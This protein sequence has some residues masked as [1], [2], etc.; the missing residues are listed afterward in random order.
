MTDLQC[1][2]CNTSVSSIIS[3]NVYSCGHLLCGNCGSD[4]VCREDGSQTAI[5]DADVLQGIS[6]IQ[7][8]CK[9]LQASESPDWNSYYMAVQ[10]LRDLVGRKYPS[11]CQKGH[12]YAGETCLRCAEVALTTQAQPLLQWV[13]NY[14]PNCKATISGT[15][16]TC[17]YKDLSAVSTVK[18]VDEEEKK[19]E[20][21]GKG[22]EGDSCW[23]CEQIAQA[24][25][26]PIMSQLQKPAAPQSTYWKCRNCNYKYCAHNLTECPNCKQPRT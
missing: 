15:C 22:Y 14:C 9:K 2:N 10:S 19:C 23:N 8:T 26:Q 18:E 25:P 17:G 11:K 12:Q 3:G 4:A 1:T 20:Q 13:P 21:C 16:S 6:D 5:Q 7:E 24:V